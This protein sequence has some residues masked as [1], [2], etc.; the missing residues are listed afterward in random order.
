MSKETTSQGVVASRSTSARTSSEIP[1]ESAIWSR[2]AHGTALVLLLGTL[3]G[4]MLRAS[5]ALLPAFLHGEA[6]SPWQAAARTAALALLAVGAAWT[7]RRTAS[8]RVLSVLAQAVLVAGAL[9][10]AIEDLPGGHAASLALSL[11]AY[12]AALILAPRILRAP[13]DGSD[14]ETEPTD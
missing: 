3:G 1:S 6:G 13:P 9:K 7:A 14:T 2:L 11:G 12:G 5:V 4:L 10:L 8:R